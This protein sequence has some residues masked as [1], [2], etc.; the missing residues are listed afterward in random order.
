MKELYTV[1]EFCEIANIGITT[2]YTLMNAQK[3]KGV[4]VGRKTLITRDSTDSWLK[5]LPSFKEQNS[6]AAG[7]R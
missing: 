1:P 5:S 2:A 3:I 6:N 4:K 7:N